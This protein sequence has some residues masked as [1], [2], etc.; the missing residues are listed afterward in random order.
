MHFNSLATFLEQLEGD[1]RLIASAR[2]VYYEEEFLSRTSNP[3]TGQAWSHIPIKVDPWRS[4]D[5]SE[6]LKELARSKSLPREKTKELDRK[7]NEVFQAN[8]ELASKPL[9]FAK[10]IDLLLEDSEFSIGA[11]LLDTLTHRFLER[12]QKEKLLDRQH[13]PLLAKHHLELLMSELAA[14]MW[15][16]E[17]HELDHESV[18]EVAEYIL[19][20]S[21]VSETARQTTAKRMPTLAFLASGDKN[22]SI[23]FEHEIF[24]FNFL[25]RAMAN[26]FAKNMDMRIMLGRSPLPEFVSERLAFE[27][28]KK[29]LLSSL[30]NIQEIFDRLSEAGHQQ[31]RRTMQVRENAGLIMLA[32]LRRFANKNIIEGCIINTV[33]FPG[34]NLQNVTLQN[35]TLADVEIRRTDL[36]TTKFIACNVSDVLLVEPRVKI[37]STRLELNGL[38]VPDEVFGIQELG[39]EG[40]TKIYAPREIIRLLEQCGTNVPATEDDDT[41]DVSDGYL[42]LLAKLMRAYERT[43]T[44]C[45]GDSNLKSLFRDPYWKRLQDLLVDHGIVKQETRPTSGR[46]KIFFRRQF[47]PD[48]I[49]KG[50]SKIADTK[51]QIVQ[52]W[53]ALE[54]VQV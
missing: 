34:S 53:D 25:A 49:M 14:E 20:D 43:N 31:W 5:R 35:C 28:E 50:E 4:E 40:I 51:P 29:D 33:V 7:V 47:S 16:Q 42:R 1:G 8:E 30:S 17:T 13:R 36:G 6:Y 54:T 52:F 46:S 37:G 23:Q 24:F 32:L 44:I 38:R 9:F 19:D 2:S 22:S 18:R 41:R 10:T 45:D 48:E 26:Q 12:E 21:Q 3:S 39:K 11:D 27:L 15:N